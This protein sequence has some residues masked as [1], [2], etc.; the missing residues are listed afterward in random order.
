MNPVTFDGL[1]QLYVTEKKPMNKVAKELGVAI[2]TVYNHLKRYGIE[3]RAQNLTFSGHH[4]T[5]ETRA[6]ISAVHKGKVV[7]AET[8]KKISEVKTNGGIGHKKL[9]SDGYIAIYFPDHPCSTK[10]GYIMEHI[11]V[12]EARIGRHLKEN[13]CVHH[14]NEN[15]TDNRKENLL[16]MTNS[17]HMAYHSKKRHETKVRDD[18]SI[19]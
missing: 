3:T 14:I 16:L 5:E 10:E 2:G 9:R 17:E 18:L 4:H 6:K 19:V 8:R 12:M 15:K 13:E 7:S 1:Y 11:L